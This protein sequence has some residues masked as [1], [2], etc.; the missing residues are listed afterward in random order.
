MTIDPGNVRALAAL[1][2]AAQLEQ[3]RY[4]AVAE[5]V[6]GHFMSGMLP[7]SRGPAGEAIYRY[8]KDAPN[9]LGEADRRGLYGRAFG[10][11]GGAADEPA[12]NVAFE[13]L[14]LRALAA[15]RDPDPGD[16]ALGDLATN[17]S[18]HGAGVA[19]FAAEELMGTMATIRAMLSH[20]EVLAAYGAA[21]HV[22]LVGRLAREQLGSDVDCAAC[23]ARAEAGSQIME[24]IALNA[25]AL[26]CGRPVDSEAIRGCVDRWL[27]V[28]AR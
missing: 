3:M 22:D 11:A 26:A 15:L 19:H 21:D 10:L 13:A 28:R 18:A 17:L 24:W 5:R 9:R 25:E 6:A 16:A 14:W 2:F 20:P 23:S 1:Y 27:E 4:F 7:L 8:V 12:P